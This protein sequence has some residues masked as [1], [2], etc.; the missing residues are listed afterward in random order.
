[1]AEIDDKAT[2]AL[3]WEG[4][5]VTGDG[6]ITA[7]I[8]Y[9]SN[10]V[11]DEDK[12]ITYGKILNITDAS[13]NSLMSFSND[14]ILKVGEWS[15]SQNGL[16]SI[17]STSE[18]DGTET[19]AVYGMTRSTPTGVNAPT[20]FLS[21]KGRQAKFYK[22]ESNIQ[23]LSNVVFKAGDHFMVTNNGTLYAN[24]GQIGTM[25]IGDIASKSYTVASDVYT[26][27]FSWKFSSTEGMFMW[28]GQ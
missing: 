16:E 1:L 3:T 6:G 24:D 11:D 21:S 22:D 28:N 17:D 27:N 8:G 12:V 5:K 25:D 23:D 15:V 19:P 9:N 2:F 14:G 26:D 4:L 20:V 10:V 7:R 13:Q 18:S